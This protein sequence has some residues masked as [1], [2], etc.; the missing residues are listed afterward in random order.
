MMKYKYLWKKEN[1]VIQ[2]LKESG[3]NIEIIQ[4][5]HRINMHKK[6]INNK[7][8]ARKMEDSYI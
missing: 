2:N 1:Q 6:T 5:V 8:Y 4:I 7:G 3:K